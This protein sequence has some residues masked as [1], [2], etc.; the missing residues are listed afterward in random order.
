M[1]LLCYVDECLMFIPSEDKID[2]VYVSIQA[3]SKIE[4]GGDIKKYTGDKQC[5]RVSKDLYRL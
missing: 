2:E 4:D 5:K 1:V 3:Y